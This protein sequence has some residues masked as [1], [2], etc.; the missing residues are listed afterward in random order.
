MKEAVLE[1]TVAAD[2]HR[3][4]QIALIEKVACAEI[5][6]EE[7]RMNCKAKDESLVT[8]KALKAALVR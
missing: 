1:L 7:I 3:S 4:E 6:L 8:E 2:S 5:E